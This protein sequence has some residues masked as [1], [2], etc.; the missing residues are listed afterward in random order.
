MQDA[1]IASQCSIF[2]CFNKPHLYVLFALGGIRFRLR[3]K[4]D[5]AGILPSL[6]S[7]VSLVIRSSLERVLPEHSCA[8]R[9][10]E[11]HLQLAA[12]IKKSHWAL[13]L[14]EAVE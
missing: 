3:S 11:I 9:D 6:S 12:D 4:Y 5:T 14:S 13:G 7:V 8:V 10:V 2:I 1:K